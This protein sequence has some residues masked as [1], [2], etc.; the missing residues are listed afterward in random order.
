M[1][2]MTVLLAVPDPTPSVPESLA[3]SIPLAV[4]AVVPVAAILFAAWLL[5]T[6]Q[7]RQ[8]QQLIGRLEALERKWGAPTP[9]AVSGPAA[10]TPSD[11][12]SNGTHP[13]KDVLAGY[14]SHVQRLIA[15]S[16]GG[17]KTLGDQAIYRIY[18][19]MEDGVTPNDLA[20]DLHVSVRTL[21]RG[22]S[23]ALGCTPN[24]LILA[25]K[26]REAHRLL[27]SGTCNVSEV[28]ARLGFSTPFYFSRRFRS[29]F[30]V[31]PSTLRRAAGD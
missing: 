28:A 11:T 3:S 14:T 17:A 6:R 30:G 4:V 20:S 15:S 5:H 29:F 9:V 8:I 27:E 22:V 7:R 13:S 31:T 1:R 26:M 2:A 23:E 24:Q 16:G 19:R 10:G 12:D 18:E 21:Q 25:M